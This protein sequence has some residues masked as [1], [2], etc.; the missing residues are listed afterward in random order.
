M[1]GLRGIICR[2]ERV[3]FLSSGGFLA[4]GS[5]LVGFCAG[6]LTVKEMFALL[7]RDIGV[8]RIVAYLVMTV[9]LN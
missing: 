6:I 4:R 1:V 5:S 7:I 2:L 9:C 3:Y 8:A